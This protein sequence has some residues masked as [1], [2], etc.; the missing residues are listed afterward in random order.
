MRIKDDVNGSQN[1]V[2]IGAPFP[3]AQILCIR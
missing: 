3:L 2:F 1:E